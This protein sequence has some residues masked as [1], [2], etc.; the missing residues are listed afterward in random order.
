MGK[1][2]LEPPRLSARDP[3]SRSSTNSDTP[4]QSLAP[5]EPTPIIARTFV[6]EGIGRPHSRW[7]IRLP[8][9]TR[10]LATVSADEACFRKNVSLDRREHLLLRTPRFQTEGGIQSVDGEEIAVSGAGRGAGTAVAGA[11]KVVDPMYGAVVQPFGGGLRLIEAGEV[12]G[13]IEQYPVRE[14]P[15]RSIWVVHYKC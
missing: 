10:R 1:G 2:G 4:P 11:A 8:E 9:C 14:H 5:G 15:D 6:A 7:P 12:G 3:K 13:Q